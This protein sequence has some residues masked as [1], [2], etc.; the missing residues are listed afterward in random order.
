[1]LDAAAIAFDRVGCALADRRIL[2][3][4]APAGMVTLSTGITA[5]TPGEDKTPEELLKEADVALY[6]AKSAGRNQVL[7]FS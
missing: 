4:G 7:A 5:F 6:R 2:H 1:V 3:P